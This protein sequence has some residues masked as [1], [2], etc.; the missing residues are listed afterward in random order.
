MSDQEQKKK[1]SKPVKGKI[2][3][4]KDDNAKAEKIQA[5]VDVGQVQKDPELMTELNRRFCL[6]INYIRE[7]ALAKSPAPRPELKKKAVAELE[8]TTEKLNSANAKIIELAGLKDG[9]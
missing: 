1:E 8:K 5:M 2:T 9:Q 4:N 3:F 7:G 6:N